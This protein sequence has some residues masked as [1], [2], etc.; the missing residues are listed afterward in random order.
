MSG[1]STSL[2]TLFGEELFGR[3]IVK[4]IEDRMHPI[5]VVTGIRRKEDMIGLSESKDFRLVY[6]EATPETRYARIHARGQNED[7]GTKT[8]EE[9]L[10]ENEFE[11][12]R[13]IRTLR[14]EAQEVIENDGS[15]EALYASLDALMRAYGYEPG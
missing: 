1:L 4:D 2:R 11:T 12:E 5:T 13:T 6:I 9:F 10:K 15:V 3:V 8:Y 7:D 14:T